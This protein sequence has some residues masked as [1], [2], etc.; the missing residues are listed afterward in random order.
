MLQLLVL[1]MRPFSRLR[2]RWVFAFG[3]MTVETLRFRV[4]LVLRRGISL[5]MNDLWLA[6]MVGMYK[7]WSTTNCRRRGGVCFIQVFAH[8][9][10]LRKSRK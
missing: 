2:L 8:C 1:L 6:R 10:C 7:S 3:D 5:L 9:S 4:L